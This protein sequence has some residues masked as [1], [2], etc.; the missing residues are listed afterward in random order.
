[1]ATC[2]TQNTVLTKHN[3]G[4]VPGL[5]Y[6]W[7][8]FMWVSIKIYWCWI[9]LG[10]SC[11]TSTWSQ[12]LCAAYGSWVHWQHVSKKEPPRNI[13]NVVAG[14]SWGSFSLL[15]RQV[16]I[17]NKPDN[18]AKQGVKWMNNS[19]NQFYILSVT[20]TVPASCWSWKAWIFSKLCINQ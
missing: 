15:K 20:Y 12:I 10:S 5:L 8:N 13:Y 9:P 3:T 18:K 6:S 11:T 1:M 4:R 19:T 2:I 16:I 14:T 7:D 17:R